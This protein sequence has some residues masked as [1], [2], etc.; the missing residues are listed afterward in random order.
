VTPLVVLLQLVGRDALVAALGALPRLVPVYVQVLAEIAFVFGLVRADGAAL[1]DGAVLGHPVPLQRHRRAAAELAQ[2]TGEHLAGFFTGA[3]RFL[4]A[5]QQVRVVGFVVALC[6]LVRTGFGV[7]GVDVVAEPVPAA[8]GVVAVGALVL[9][10]GG[11]FEALVPHQLY[12]VHRDERAFVA[13]ED[14]HFVGKLRVWGRRHFDRVRLSHVVH[15]DDFAAFV[16]SLRWLRLLVDHARQIY[17]ALEPHFVPAQILVDLLFG[18][19]TLV[20]EVVET[21]EHAQTFPAYTGLFRNVQVLQTTPI[22]TRISPKNIIYSPSPARTTVT[23]LSVLYWEF[24]CCRTCRCKSSHFCRHSVDK[25]DK[26]STF[27]AIKNQNNK[28]TR[29]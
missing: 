9:V 5:L 8:R 7:L 6:A 4:V 14:H 12:L 27:W 16:D 26:L 25:R 21:L 29:D 3:V 20:F 13:R 11:H 23:N 19:Q 18:R 17:L 24:A 2:G 10:K 15:L 22:S 28:P 1:H